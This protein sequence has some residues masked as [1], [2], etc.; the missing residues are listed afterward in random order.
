MKFKAFLKAFKRAKRPNHSKAAAFEQMTD[1][2]GGK[3]FKR[4]SKLQ[5]NQQ[6][7]NVATK[8]IRIKAG[9]FFT[10]FTFYFTFFNLH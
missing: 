6:R 9:A 4:S 8:Y 10:N 1:K 3:L 5:E 7:P 2:W